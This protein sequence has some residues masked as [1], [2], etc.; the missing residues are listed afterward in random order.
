MNWYYESGGQQQGP[1][2]DA[3]LDRLLAEGK[4]TVDTLIWREGMSGWTPLRTARPAAAATAPPG[5]PA[6]LGSSAPAPIAGAVPSA[7]SGS[8]VPQPGWIRCSLTGRYFP[9]SEIIY[10]EG[11]PYSAAAKPQVVATLQSGGT[12]PTFE[13]G[14]N[15]PAWE[16]RQ[17]LGFVQAIVQTCKGV[18]LSPRDTFATMKREGG[19]QTPF[20]FNLIVGSA[21]GVIVQILT[22]IAQM[23]AFGGGAAA[24][25]AGA[26]APAGVMVGAG[27]FGMII[28]IIMTPIQVAFGAFVGPGITHACLVLLKAANR[29]FETTFRALNY[30][31]GGLAPAQLVL[32]IGMAF[33]TL[34]MSGSPTAGGAAMGVV[35]LIAIPF[36][37]WA[38]YLSIVAVSE[39]QDITRG[40]AAAAILLPLVVCCGLIVVVVV[41]VGGIAAMNANR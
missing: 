24:A 25:G 31:T 26:G 11:K 21:A 12:L 39:T 38:L 29:P 3:D 27:L 23:V 5:A 1:V 36:G 22:S 4:I 28:G 6:S 17:T 8:D 19:I 18:I 14:R 2:T 9:P 40:K 33:A 13:S 34:V 15:G 30:L 7:T 37:I 16:Q 41:A 32:G 35:G 20:I 10:L